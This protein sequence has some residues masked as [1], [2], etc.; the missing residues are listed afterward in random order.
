MENKGGNETVVSAISQPE[1]TNTP[2]AEELARRAQK[3]CRQ[4]FAALVG[5]YGERLFLFLR[6][7]TGNI[8]DAEDLV[9]D[10]FVKAYQ[11]IESYNSSAK[12]STWLFTI[13]CRLAGS[14]YRR[15]QR[16]HV[17]ANVEPATE[18]PAEATERR[19]A[20]QN[21]WE[22]AA[23]LPEGQYQALWLRY[24][25]DMPVRQIAKVL[26]KSQV[27]VR[28]LLCRARVNLSRK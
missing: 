6:H 12:F 18:G 26:R 25:E 11:N 21:L 5:R 15:A 24:V 13:A 20:R 23:C 9:Q 8:E 16:T 4:S 28:V 17:V 10:T 3:G 22:L 27:H 7:R 19:E 2:S 14:H 1:K